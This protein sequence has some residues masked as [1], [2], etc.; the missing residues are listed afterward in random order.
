VFV[1][2]VTIAAVV[3]VCRLWDLFR[4]TSSATR[5]VVLGLIDLVAL[6][7]LR[8]IL[9][10]SEWLLKWFRSQPSVL[11]SRGQRRQRNFCSC[12]CVCC[13]EAEELAVGG[14]SSSFF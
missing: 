1:T 7:R 4:L 12:C 14:G 5:V 2:A 9:I 11:N 10:G 3:V 13:G 8:G 6:S